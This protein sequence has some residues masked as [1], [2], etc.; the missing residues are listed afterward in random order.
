M[1]N[2]DYLSTNASPSF[3]IP[4]S[5]STEWVYVMSA[6]S[7]P[8]A[9]HHANKLSSEWQLS[10]AGLERPSLRSGSTRNLYRPKMYAVP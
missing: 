3:P 5:I 10:A 8:T 9:P 7:E 1:I 4:V 6:I 2:H